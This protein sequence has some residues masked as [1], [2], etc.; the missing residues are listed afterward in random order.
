MRGL[1]V[2]FISV[3]AYAGALFVPANAAPFTCPDMTVASAPG[4]AP[5]LGGLSSGADD[6]AASNRLRELVAELR[7]R[8]LKPALI[9]DQLVGSYCPL[10]AADGALSDNQ[11]AER[12]RRFAQLATGLAYVSSDSNEVDILVQ[13]ALTPGLLG[14]ID[15]AA[16]RT[17]ISRNAWIERAIKQQL[18]VP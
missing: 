9:V 3:A 18:T 15:E 6:A 4:T 12:V 14:Q 16:A 2:A 10:V 7:N 17:G 13:M 5:S 1:L 11:K 8:G